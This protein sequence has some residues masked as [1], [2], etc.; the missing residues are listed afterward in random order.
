MMSRHAVA[1]I[2]VTDPEPLGGLRARLAR[3]VDGAF[4]DLVRL[5]E[6]GIFSGVRRLIS[7]PADA[8]DITQE[9]FIRAHR[10]LRVYDSEQIRELRVR[11]WLWTIALNLCRNQARTRKRRPA[12]ISLHPAFEPADHAPGPEA[13][14]LE[15]E[16]GRDW[17]DLL[18]GLPGPMR[19]AVVLRH[20]VGLSIAEIAEALERSEGTVKS[21]LHRGLERL[22]RRIEGGTR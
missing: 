20:V 22:R 21:D 3:D 13:R 19:S 16:A 10:A 2:D 15:S 12:A 17:R 1:V 6:A 4:A 11:P 8:E 5:T 14:A 18:R 9:T 7:N